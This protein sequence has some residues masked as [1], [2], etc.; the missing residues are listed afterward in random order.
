MKA[1]RHLVTDY[2]AS[3]GNDHHDV[4]DLLPPQLP[5]KH[6]SAF[7]DVDIQM[8]PRKARVRASGTVFLL[9]P[10][11]VSVVQLPR[12]RVPPLPLDV[13]LHLPRLPPF[14][15]DFLGGDAVDDVGGS[16]DMRAGPEVI[17]FWEMGGP[18]GG[19]AG[20]HDTIVGAS[21]HHNHQTSVHPPASQHHGNGHEH[22]GSGGG[23]AGHHKPAKS[24]VIVTTSKHWVTTTHPQHHDREGGKGHTATPSDQPEGRGDGGQEDEQADG[25]ENDRDRGAL[26]SLARE[27]GSMKPTVVIGGLL[28]IFA[29]AYLWGTVFVTCFK[30]NR[31]PLLLDAASSEP[32][33]PTAAQP[34]TPSASQSPAEPP[35]QGA[36]STS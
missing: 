21:D 10:E 18:D 11:Q 30:P 7:F 3:L 16:D 8:P 35:S 33:A 19:S 15:D 25:G 24:R 9:S 17:E 29:Q 23:D 28:A 2:F 5:R 13:Q 31:R 27:N 34:S 1:C 4:G 32:S 26:V 14:V 22:E 6:H 20:H 12:H 36:A